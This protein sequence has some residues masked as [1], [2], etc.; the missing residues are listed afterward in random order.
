MKDQ[1]PDLN[2]RSLLKAI[3]IGSA[4]G[5]AI[6]A[7]GVNAAQASEPVEAKSATKG[8]HETAHIRSYYN[9]LRS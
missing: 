9:S 6:A 1:K 7:T 5:A 8:Y 2:R 4:A 3:T